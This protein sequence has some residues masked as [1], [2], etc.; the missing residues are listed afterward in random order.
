MEKNHHHSQTIN[1]FHF[2]LKVYFVHF[3]IPGLKEKRESHRKWKCQD[4]GN[5][6]Q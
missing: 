2:N 6:N 4:Y 3:S 1:I 5:K